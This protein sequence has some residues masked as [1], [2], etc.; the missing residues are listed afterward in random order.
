MRLFHYT[1]FHGHSGWFTTMADY[2]KAFPSIDGRAVRTAHVGIEAPAGYRKTGRELA[3]DP[4]E[5]IPTM[6]SFIASFGK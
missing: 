4:V 2:R 3:C 6:Q 1:D 5:R